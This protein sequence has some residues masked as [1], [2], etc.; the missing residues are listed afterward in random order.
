M[1]IT[2]D[3]PAGAGKSTAAR[4]LAHALSIPFLD[5]GAMYRA[6]TLKALEELDDLGDPQALAGIARRAD[7]HLVP[8]GEGTTVQLDGRDIS[9]DIRTQR[10]TDNAHYIASCPAVREVLV[11]KQRQVGAELGSFV[12]EGRDQGSVVFPAAEHKFFIVAS[13]EIRARRRV[14]QLQAAG[15]EA[16][17]EDILQKIIQRD[18]RDSSR[19][20]APLVKPDGAVEIDTSDT[21]PQQ[22]IQQMLAVIGKGS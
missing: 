21:T 6:L 17:Y 1:I 19:A 10:V 12:T 16:D 7:L 2:I 11:D 20:V 22:V 14:E 13:P 4:N 18:Q 9:R 5:T 15:E 3:G 8:H